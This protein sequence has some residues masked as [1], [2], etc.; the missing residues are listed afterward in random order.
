MKQNYYLWNCR[1]REYKRCQPLIWFL[2]GIT[3]RMAREGP[4]IW[5]VYFLMERD[6]TLAEYHRGIRCVDAAA[7]ILCLQLITYT[8]RGY[9]AAQARRWKRSSLFCQLPACPV[10]VPARCLWWWLRFHCCG[11]LWCTVQC[12]ALQRLEYDV[13]QSGQPVESC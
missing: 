10:A 13:Q 11:A 4:L 7:Y 8:L 9:V 12:S 2:W 6:A 3:E 5:H 1:V